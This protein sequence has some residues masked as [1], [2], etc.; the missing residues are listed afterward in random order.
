MEAGNL[1]ISHNFFY[2]WLTLSRDG[3]AP[4]PFSNEKVTTSGTLFLLFH[5]T[6]QHDYL[7][8]SYPGMTIVNLQDYICYLMNLMKIKKV[9]QNITASLFEKY[10]T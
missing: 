3:Y 5:F 1:R 8:S 10:Q 4:V 2:V 7:R 9:V 6:V